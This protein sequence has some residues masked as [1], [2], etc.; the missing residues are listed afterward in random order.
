MRYHKQL[1][2]EKNLTIADDFKSFRPVYVVTI[3]RPEVKNAVDKAT[4]HALYDA[5]QR[6][7]QSNEFAVAILRSS[8]STRKQQF[9]SLI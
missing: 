8:G 3:K 9:A 7:D 1:T 2:Y 4:A 5:F 6:F